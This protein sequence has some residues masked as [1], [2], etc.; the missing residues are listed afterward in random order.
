MKKAF[1][2]IVEGRNKIVIEKT[3]PEYIL[4]LNNKKLGVYGTFQMAERKALKLMRRM[5]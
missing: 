2:T 3:L 1:V 5:V 4:K